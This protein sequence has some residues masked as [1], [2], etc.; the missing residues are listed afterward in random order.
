MSASLR[1]LLE[2]S[3]EIC[4]CAKTNIAASAL[5]YLVQVVPV[6]LSFIT[7]YLALCY[8]SF[9]KLLFSDGFE[10]KTFPGLKFGEIL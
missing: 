1:F 5:K 10:L 7:V 2:L 9:S 3:Q 6:L 8:C 4:A